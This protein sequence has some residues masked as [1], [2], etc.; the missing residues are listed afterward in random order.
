MAVLRVIEREAGIWKGFR[1]I[2]VRA[3]LRAIES[4][5]GVWNIL[6][7]IERETGVNTS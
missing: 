2:G 3:S 5:P 1:V 4:E 6:R 7:V